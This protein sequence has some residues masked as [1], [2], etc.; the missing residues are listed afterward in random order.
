MNNIYVPVGPHLPYPTPKV[1]YALGYVH[2]LPSSRVPFGKVGAI[3]TNVQNVIDEW[4]H[5]QA[6]RHNHWARYVVLERVQPVWKE[7]TP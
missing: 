2:D 1:Q 6:V 5:L 3:D 7:Y 4:A